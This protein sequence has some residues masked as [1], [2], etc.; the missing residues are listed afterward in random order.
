MRRGLASRGGGRC[1]FL[2][3]TRGMAAARAIG[4][5]VDRLAGRRRREGLSNKSRQAHVVSQDRPMLAHYNVLEN[6]QKPIN[7]YRKI[8]QSYLCLAHP[9][10]L[11][12]ERQE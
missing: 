10:R 2:N 9:P 3:G 12:L 5:G 7:S 8:A 4:D 6:P 1:L 11:R